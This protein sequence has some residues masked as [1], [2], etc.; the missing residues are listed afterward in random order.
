MCPWS[1]VP[2]HAVLFVTFAA[3]LL[4]DVCLLFLL[5]PTRSLI[6]VGAAAAAVAAVHRLRLCPA[7]RTS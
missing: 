3:Q 2:G 4:P 5:L 1:T 6:F 7:M